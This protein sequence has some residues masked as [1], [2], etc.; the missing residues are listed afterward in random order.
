MTTPMLRRLWPMLMLFATAMLPATALLLLA[1]CAG[2][3]S[4]V[5]GNGVLLSEQRA[6][7][8]APFDSVDLRGAMHVTI[9][10]DPSIPEPAIEIRADENLIPLVTTEV[11]SGTLHIDAE[12]PLSSRNEIRVMIVTPSLAGARISGSGDLMA[13][14]I[15]AQIFTGRVSG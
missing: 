2:S 14:G 6:A 15:E 11:R 7:P 9:T 13:E 10:V 4:A 8:P 3:V 1:G 12:R 5:R